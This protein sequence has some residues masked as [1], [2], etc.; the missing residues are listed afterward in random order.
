MGMTAG[1]RSKRM[2][3]LIRISRTA[4]YYRRLNYHL[5]HLA[6]LQ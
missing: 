2:A 5:W 4:E 3:S 1:N 6:N